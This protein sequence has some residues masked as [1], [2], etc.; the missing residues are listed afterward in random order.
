M[1]LNMWKYPT[2]KRTIRT[3][4]IVTLVVLSVFM[5]MWKA[6]AQKHAET[7]TLIVQ[8][9]SP[10]AMI[11]T[12]EGVGG[13]VLHT[14]K[15][16]NAVS[17]VLTKEQ[18][19]KLKES[20]PL[21]SFF[22][23]SKVELNDFAAV[24]KAKPLKFKLSSSEVSWKASLNEKVVVDAIALSWPKA[25]GNLSELTVN[26]V[27][28]TLV[29]TMGGFS[30]TLAEYTLAPSNLLKVELAFDDIS[31]VDESDYAISVT[32]S[33]GQTIAL[34]AEQTLVKRGKNRDTYVASQT[35]A[36]EA[37][38]QGVTGKGVTVA[39]I[40]S[41]LSSFKQISKNSENKARSIFTYNAIDGSDDVTDEFGHGTHVTSLI[42]NSSQKYLDSKSKTNSYNGVAPDVNLL[43]V[44]A[45]DDK[46][47]ATY[48]DVLKA[49]DYVVA[50]KDG[51][52]I[53]VLNLSFSAPPSSFYWQDPINQALMVAWQNG[54]TVV[55]SAG[56]RGSD[57]MTI[58][59]PGN[60]PYVVTVGAV[61]DNYTPYDYSDDFLTTFSSA[62]PTIEGFIKPEIIA[63]GG[64]VQGLLSDD[65]YIAQNFALYDTGKDYYE[66]SG[67]SQSTA[68]TSGI[69]ALLL[70]AN[71]E[72]TPDLV[73]CHLLDSAKLMVTEEKGLAFSLFQ[74]GRGVVDTM[75]ALKADN[76]HCID[77][78]QALALEIANEEHY[79]GPVEY[80]AETGEHYLPGLEDHAWD[81]VYTDGTLWGKVKYLASDGT[82]WGKVKYVEADGTLWGKVKYLENDGT[83]WGKVKYIDADGSLWREI[84][85]LE[86]DGTLWGKV[87]YLEASG[88][89]WGKVK[90]VETDG[91]L[92][93][94]V[95]YLEN[96]TFL[97]ES[98]K[99]V[100]TS[101][102]YWGQ[103]KV[104]DIDGS[105]SGQ[106]KVF[107]TESVLWGEESFINTAGTLWGKVK[108]IQ[109]DGTLWGKVKYVETDGTLWGKVKYLGTD[110]T[111]WGKVKYLDADGTLWGRV[112]YLEANGALWGDAEDT[113]VGDGS[114]WGKM[115]SNQ[116]EAAI[117][118]ANLVDPE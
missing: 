117:I 2:N 89:L 109:A 38:F 72:L 81:G 54:I 46:G 39:V 103:E 74:Q 20:A 16:I 30:Q 61:S 116:V 77:N 76:E 98:I 12:I 93:G 23:D 36:N 9:A 42:V 8:G 67:T 28:I 70:S 84:Q 37:H 114:L 18:Q 22:S 105:L 112:K 110:G 71:P 21:L 11:E 41:G 118:E 56:N 90:Y 3:I 87:K 49:I 57:D 44:K 52:N 64:H 59:V 40:D 34:E 75:L 33:D 51:L 53:K 78:S 91:T 69:A 68:L 100:E 58:G 82:L 108:Y 1:Q 65:S 5:F 62:G 66:I 111:L 60:N 73:K 102:S 115:K 97:W 26:D 31:S 80:N 113:M 29:P 4:S 45:F 27:D 24:K 63:P 86:S 55:A 47:L 50:N 96:D 43:A 106:V 95:K 19:Q 25:N 94:K 79:L 32:L 92:W 99:D 104:F 48:V 13:E 35:R 10:K 7:K 101:G 15:V 85:H 14:F 88:T 17:A 83:L 107:E 6:Q